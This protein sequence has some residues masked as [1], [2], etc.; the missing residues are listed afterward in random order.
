MALSDMAARRAQPTGKDYTLNDEDGLALFV[1]ANGAKSW[2]FRFYWLDK[3]GRISFGTYPELGLKQ[4]RERRDEARSL[5]AQGIDPRAHRREAQRSAVRAAENSFQAVYERWRDHKALSLRS[6]RQSTLSQ[7]KRIFA[8]D[9]L[10]ILGVRS[11][12][13]VSR[14]D[15]VEVLRKVEKRK[16]LTTAEKLR[17]WFNQLFR[18]TMVELDLKGNP[19]ADLDI[20]AV[21]KAPI[22]HNPFLRMAQVPEFLAKLKAYGGDE[23]TRLGLWILLLTGVR[24]GEL[25]FATPDQ[26]DLERGLWIIPPDIVKQ[27]QEKVRREGN[28]D[29]S[30]IPPYVVPLSCQAIAVFQRLLALRPPGQRYV[31]GHRSD[32]NKRISENTLNAALIRMGY[33]DR[34]T[35]HGIRATIS[36]ALNES[37]YK[38]DWVEAQLSHSEPNKIRAAYNHADYVEPRRQMMQEWANRLERLVQGASEPAEHREETQPVPDSEVPATMVALEAVDVRAD[39]APKEPAPMPHFLARTDQRPRLAMTDIQRERAYMLATYQSAHNMVLPAFAKLVGKSRHQVNREIQA[40][41]LLALSLGN[42]GYRI[43]DWQLDPM[44][45][46][47]TQE[48]MRRASCS[49]AWRIYQML[50][51]PLDELNGRSAV[52]AVSGS[53]VDQI[54]ELVGRVDALRSQDFADECG[55]LAVRIV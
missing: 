32:P 3:R 7:I 38:S 48:A 47:L 1:G 26:I 24:T 12:F 22:T 11:I 27:L 39:E 18:W 14:A 6:G 29:G 19:A 52:E 2:H 25:R 53:N 10:P 17:T 31:L 4:A 46:R 36:T 13:D 42:R 40:G 45:D 50:T 30:E 49:D 44:R 41:K 35:G 21:P 33:K 54:V 23:R 8:K 9:V 28:K 16:A 51:Q 20:V 34:L 5:V 37:G 43:P 15:L 55:G